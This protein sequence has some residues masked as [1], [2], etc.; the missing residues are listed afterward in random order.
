MTSELKE[1]EALLNLGGISLM[2][3]VEP[4]A[5]RAASM[6]HHPAAVPFSTSGIGHSEKKLLAEKQPVKA[7]L[8]V[9]P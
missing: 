2:K 8:T 5:K 3:G 4:R 7:E 9:K 6:T 1:V